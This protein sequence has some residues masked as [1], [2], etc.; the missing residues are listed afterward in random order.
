MRAGRDHLREARRGA[1]HVAEQFAHVVVRAQDRQELDRGV[2]T[3]HAPP[4][5]AASAASA[6]P[7]PAKASS[8]AGRQFR[9]DLAGARAAHRRPAAEMPAA[10]RL[11]RRVRALEAERGAASPASPDRR[12][13]PVKTRLPAA[14]L[15]VGR[16]LEQARIVLLDLGQMEGQVLREGLEP[17]IAAEF[18]EAGERLRARTAGAGSARRRPSAAGARRVRKKR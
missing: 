6:S 5:K 17:R 15:S 1:Q 10:D 16:V 12:A 7:E 4:S 14:A 8:S 18:G 2:H 3:R 11:G 13:T 9:Q